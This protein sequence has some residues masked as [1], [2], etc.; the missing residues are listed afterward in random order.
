MLTLLLLAIVAATPSAID[1]ELA[2]SNE[3]KRNGQWA[4]FRSYAGADAVVF[5]PRATWARDFLKGK[6][7]G[8]IR[9]SPNA[10][11]GSC[12]GEMAVNTGPWRD[13]KSTQAGF[14]TTVWEHQK[15]PV[16][17]DFSRQAHPLPAA[18]ATQYPNRAQSLMSRS[19]TRS[20]AHGTAPDK[21]GP[22][23][24]AGRFWSGI[25]Q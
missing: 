12:D 11:Y 2:F 15:W 5:T 21:E 23:C 4:A 14:F 22:R 13:A 10:S 19:R 20:A 8:E 24:D 18:C 7:G 3:A 6:E 16:E 1:A 17:M 9:W 25:F